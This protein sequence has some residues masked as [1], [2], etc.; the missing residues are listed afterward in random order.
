MAKDIN[1]FSPSWRELIFKDKNQEYGAYKLRKNS[2]RYHLVAFLIIVAAAVL[3]ASVPK[4]I[5]LLPTK[6]DNREESRTTV[7]STIDDE[8]QDADELQKLSSALPPPE[9]IRTS[10]KFTAPVITE[11]SKVNDEDEMRTQDELAKSTAAISIRDVQGTD[12]VDAEDIKD[13]IEAGRIA[14]SEKAKDEVIFTIVEQH[15]TYPGGDDKMRQF[16]RDEMK[17]PAIA[18]EAGIQGTVYIE[19]TCGKDGSIRDVT[20]A[21]GVIQVLDDEAVRVVKLMPKWLPGR[22]R[23]QAVTTRFT[24]PIQ[25]VLQ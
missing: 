24:I 8:P 14:Q 15:A 22:Q 7:I 5:E 2:S 21:R 4:L 17:Y 10:I 20:V 23:G 9:N 16:L 12:D 11:D 19:F 18:R 6:V 1:I 25:F 13:I 3:I